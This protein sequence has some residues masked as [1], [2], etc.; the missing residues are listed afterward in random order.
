MQIDRLAVLFCLE[1]LPFMIRFQGRGVRQVCSLLCTPCFSKLSTLV[2]H[3]SGWWGDFFFFGA[4]FFPCCDNKYDF[5]SSVVWATSFK[6][7]ERKKIYLSVKQFKSV[8]NLEMPPNLSSFQFLINL[9]VWST[10]EVYCLSLAR[11]SCTSCVSKCCAPLHLP[12]VAACFTQ[13]AECP[14]QGSQQKCKR[15]LLGLCQTIRTILISYFM[16]YVE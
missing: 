11:F 1:W 13:L 4:F 7:S 6:G 16:L 8:L 14:P 12:L 10:S 3:H 2:P 5:Y 15:L 9:M